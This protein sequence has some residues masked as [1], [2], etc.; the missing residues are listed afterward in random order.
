MTTELNNYM[1]AQLEKT[2][3]TMIKI[4]MELSGKSFEE[5]K[6]IVKQFI[7]NL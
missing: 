1:D 5:A 3:L 2:F 7:N 4:E 6:V